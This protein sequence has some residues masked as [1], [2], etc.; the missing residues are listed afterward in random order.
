M[1]LLPTIPNVVKQIALRRAAI[2]HPNRPARVL[3]AEVLK[4]LGQ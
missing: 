3:L 2:R 4:E 1:S